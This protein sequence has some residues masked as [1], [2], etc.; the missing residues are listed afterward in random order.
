MLLDSPPRS[1]PENG[2]SRPNSP[3][4]YL[5]RLADEGV[6]LAEITRSAHFPMY[7]NPTEMCSRI[8]D[9]VLQADSVR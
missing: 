6:E 5:P 7:S 4:S 1:W 9:F 8:T 2:R 3:L